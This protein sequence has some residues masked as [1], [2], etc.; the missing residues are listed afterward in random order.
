MAETGERRRRFFE[1]LRKEL[2][3]SEQRRA[4]IDAVISR[5]KSLEQDVTGSIVGLDEERK[6]RENL[7]ESMRSEREAM[8][9]R[10]ADL[11]RELSDLVGKIRGI[12]QAEELYQAEM[13][14]L[15]KKEEGILERAEAKLREIWLVQG[16]T[17]PQEAHHPSDEEPHTEV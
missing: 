4:A 15:Q 10:K 17:P 3:A 6:E 9:E 13:D 8:S 5:L 7:K 16:E 14:G 2:T 11:E 1:E 12:E